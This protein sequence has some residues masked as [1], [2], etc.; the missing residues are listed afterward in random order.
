MG[1][2]FSAARS[3]RSGAAVVLAA[4]TLAVV[5]PPA[6]QAAG[7]VLT[8]K[9]PA[10][11]TRS[12]TLQQ[13]KTRF[14]A[15]KGY[16]GYVKTGFVGMEKPHPVKGVRL[17]DLL[18]KV[19]YKKGGVTLTA[20]DGYSYTYSQNLVRGRKVTMYK[21]SAPKYPVVTV[22]TTNPLTA[23]VAY[24]DKKIGARVNDGNPWRAYTST[25]ATNGSDGL[26]PLRFWWSYRKWANPGF[27]QIGWSSMRMVRRVTV[28]K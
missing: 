1:R 8:V 7:V 12:Y 28:S 10:G 4:V 21:A 27:I 6:A 13:L 20:A 26:G 9:G 15:Y 3:W 14:T 11:K 23:I 18:A 5:L 16:A 2:G 22:P 17:L 24:Q 25:Y 19:G